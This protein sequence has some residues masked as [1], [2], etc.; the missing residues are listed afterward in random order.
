[1][2][3]NFLAAFTIFLA[4][5]TISVRR[6]ARL[7]PI[8]PLEDERHPNREHDHPPPPSSEGGDEA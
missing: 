3:I 1:M 6:A 4:L 2:V 7:P 8:P 5:V